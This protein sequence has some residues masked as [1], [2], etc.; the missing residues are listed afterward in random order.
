MES[1]F[2]LA[3]FTKYSNNIEYSNKISLVFSILLFVFLCFETFKF[4]SDNSKDQRVLQCKFDK[5]NEKAQNSLQTILN[6]ENKPEK[7]EKRNYFIR[8]VKIC[9]K[10]VFFVIVYPSFFWC[11]SKKL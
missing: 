2:F 3:H 4:F 10:I 11:T 5:I 7:K 1:D 8:Q 9:N 6:E